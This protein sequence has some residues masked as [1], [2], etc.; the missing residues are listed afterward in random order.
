MCYL[1]SD[2]YQDQFGGDQNRK[3]M[4]YRLKALMVAH[5]AKPVDQQQAAFAQTFAAWKGQGPQIDDVLLMGFR[6]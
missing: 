3:F 2:G 4:P 1:Y 6:V 5:A